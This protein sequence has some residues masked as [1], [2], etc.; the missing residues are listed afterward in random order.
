MIRHAI[1]VDLEE[2]FHVM[3]LRAFFPPSSWEG[4]ERRSAAAVEKLLGILERHSVKATFFCLGWLAEREPGLVKEI[5]AAGHEIASHG[6][7]HRVLGDLG[8]EGFRKELSRTEEILEGITGKRPLLHRACSFSIVPAT[9]WALEILASRGYRGDSSIFP[10]AH[11][12]Y[13]WKGF[14][15]RPVEVETEGG[16]IVEFPPLTLEV[17]GRNLPAGGG[18]YLRLFPVRFLSFALRRREKEG[19]PGCVYLHPW[20]LDPRQPRPGVRGIKRFRHYVNL[21][22]TAAKLD[23]LL[24][25][26]AFGTMGEVLDGLRGKIPSIPLPGGGR[27]EPMGPPRPP[28]PS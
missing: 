28:E 26:H 20:E 13:G 17:L 24:G 18:G 3:N 7:G 1:T 22:R 11:P 4:L 10:V 2:W 5:S 21:G 9:R 23:K 12:D 19:V 6:Y 25:K 8:P 27:P 15:A 16:R 14:P